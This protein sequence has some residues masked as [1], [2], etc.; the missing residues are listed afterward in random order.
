MNRFNI[1]DT[2]YCFMSLEN[3]CVKGIIKGDI[4]TADNNE[5]YPVEIDSLVYNVSAANIADTPD[6]CTQIARSNASAIIDK[7]LATIPNNYEALVDFCLSCID[8]YTQNTKEGFIDKTIIAEK[9]DMI[10]KSSC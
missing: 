9:L 8:K 3:P 4:V 1:N 2:V 7:A 10:K 6:V 5:W